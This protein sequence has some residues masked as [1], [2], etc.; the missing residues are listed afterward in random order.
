MELVTII[1]FAAIFLVF[2]VYTVL[3]VLR[4]VL[5]TKREKNNLVFLVVLLP[6]LGSLLAIIYIK[7]K[8]SARK[9]I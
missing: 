8:Q 3:F 4:A 5:M 2:I 1:L 7:L 6:F 9:T